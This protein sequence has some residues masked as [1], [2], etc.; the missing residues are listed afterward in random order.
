MSTLRSQPSNDFHAAPPALIVGVRG[1]VWLSAEGEV[2]EISHRLAARRIATGVRPL[3][4]Y[5][6]LAAKRLKI[7]PFPALDLLELF[8]FVYPARFCL[9]T[10]GGLAEALDISLP[11]TLEAEAECLMAAAECLFDRLAAIAKPDVAAVARFM[12]QGGWPW[13]GMVLAALGE[14]GEA[15][16]SKSLIAGM[17]IW[18]RLPEWQDQPP[19][20]PPGAFPVEPVEARAQLV[21]LLGAGSEDR[22]QQM[23]YAAGV[24]AAF[25]PRD[26]V[27]Q[28]RFVLAEAGTGVG[29]TLGY[30][31]SAS[32]WAEKNEGP[33]WVSTFTR[34]LQRQLDAELDR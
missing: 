9:P 27:D 33:V 28:P 5:G 19:K 1:A 3:V 26:H 16:H 22:P 6:P 17:R 11:G 34:N 24:S 21:R 20:P 32:V 4:C 13:G 7:E 31:A 30:I 15:P 2:E 25:M 29:K 10:P 18:D 14:S 12:A 23:D 8:A